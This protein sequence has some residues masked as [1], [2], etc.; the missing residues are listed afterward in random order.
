MTRLRYDGLTTTLGAAISSTSATSITF[1][2]GLQ[3]MGVDIP[4][5]SGDYLV[6]VIDDEIVYLTAYT[7]G[8]TSGTISRGEEG[9]TAAT[10]SNGAS[11]VHGPT[12]QDFV[13][14]G[15]SGDSSSLLELG[16][17]TVGASVETLSITAQYMKKVTVPAGGAFLLSV[18][19]Y[20]KNPGSSVGE[21]S[22]GL[23]ADVAG[24]PGKL[25]AALP[26]TSQNTVYMVSGEGARWMMFPLTTWLAA[27]DYWLALFHPGA[28]GAVGFDIYYDTGGSD[29]VHST[30]TNNTW[31]ADSAAYSSSDTTKNYSIK[32]QLLATSSVAPPTGVT[33]TGAKTSAYTAVNGDMVIADATSG[34]VPITLPAATAGATVAAKKIDTSANVVT[35][36]GASGALIDGDAAL[37]LV[38]EDAG[39]TLVADG[40]NWRVV[41]TAFESSAGVAW[42]TYTP[43]V[44]AST[45]PPTLGTGAVQFGEY[46]DDNSIVHFTLHIVFGTSPT[47]GSGTYR[48]AFP[49]TGAATWAAQQAVV[50]NGTFYDASADQTYV[51]TARMIP[52]NAGVVSCDLDATTGGGLGHNKPV[53]PAAGDEIWIRGTYRKAS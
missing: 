15:G 43:A 32:A 35:V 21:I 36:T 48:F 5:I 44:T 4:T 25:I 28:A 19:A 24:S 37:Y 9:T 27:G 41:S 23:M 2:A 45:T 31:L 38:S 16:T 13:A 20:V 51:L 1:A 17:T 18:G 34:A 7:S 33:P 40:T 47:V 14:G 11:V 46:V 42:T 39:C 50:G 26:T 52:S 12:V 49:V 22:V 6:L 30:G 10:H 53:A 29:R 3:T 8:A